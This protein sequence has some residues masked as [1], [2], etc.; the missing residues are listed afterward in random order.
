M[1][2]T[3]LFCNV[4]GTV[5]TYYSTVRTIEEYCWALSVAFLR[6]EIVDRIN[7]DDVFV[8]VSHSQDDYISIR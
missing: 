7:A 1:Q 4:R 3:L 6:G 2:F 8:E 5:H